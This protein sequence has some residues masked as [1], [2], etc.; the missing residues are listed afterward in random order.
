MNQSR[1][2]RLA[3]TLI[4]LLVVIAIIA[5]LVALLLPA[6]QQAREAARRSSCKN[7]LKQLGVAMHNYHDTHGCL[8]PGFMQGRMQDGSLHTW[9][10]WSG[11]AMILPYIE[12]GPLYDQCNFD[13]GIVGDGPTEQ[14]NV[15]FVMQQI[16]AYLC[17]SDLDATGSWYSM[18][19]PGNNY[20]L[21]LGTTLDWD[22]TNNRSGMFYRQSHIR[23]RDVLDG[24][25]S[26]IMMAEINKGQGGNTADRNFSVVRAVPYTGSSKSPPTV[27]DMQTY[28]QAIETALAN[29]STNNH[30]HA[31]RHWAL[32]QH[33][34]S[35]FNTS[36]TPNWQYHSGQECVNC[37]WMDSDGAFPSRS[38]HRGGSQH[39][40]GDGSVHFISENIDGG[41]YQALGSR[42]GNETVQFP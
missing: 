16:P 25:S 38:R 37:G 5:I 14:I 24:L 12:M 30:N 23:F 3:F 10:G 28:G 22:G 41:M 35:L 9:R 19:Y 4:E 27:A 20:A 1:K 31:G 17:P 2:L 26:T 21:S 42:N 36:A 34:Q 6:V 8:P 15:D 11:L 7:N 32:G 18:P 39:L 13:Y 40:F 33:Y 29:A